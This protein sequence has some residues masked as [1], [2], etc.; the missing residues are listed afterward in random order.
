M[1]TDDDEDDEEDEDDDELEDDDAAVQA[2]LTATPK[3]A[4]SSCSKLLGGKFG[5]DD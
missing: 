1:M 3:S 4:F 5:R 2:R